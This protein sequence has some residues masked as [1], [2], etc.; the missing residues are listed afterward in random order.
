MT[1]QATIYDKW[2]NIVYSSNSLNEDGMPDVPWNGR[3][4]NEGDVL[5]MGAY[6]WKI[7]AIFDDGTIWPGQR[8][9]NENNKIFNYGSVTLIR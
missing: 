3:Y 7:E 4:M 9:K 5:P 2:G 1:Y 8:N 6:V